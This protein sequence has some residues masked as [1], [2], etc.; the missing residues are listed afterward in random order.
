MISLVELSA[1][2]AAKYN[3]FLRIGLLNHP[4]TLRIAPEDLDASP[5]STAATPDGVTLARQHHDGRLAAVGSVEREHGR[6]KRRHIAWIL[7]MYSAELRVGHARAILSELL[8]RAR[9]MPGV[10]KVNLTVAAHNESA[11]R[12]YASFGFVEFAREPLAFRGR[13]EYITELSMTLALE[14]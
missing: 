1:A 10:E 3:S 6:L 5:I 14:L 9:R 8:A 13:D 2:D 7:R 4:D 11:V 12:L